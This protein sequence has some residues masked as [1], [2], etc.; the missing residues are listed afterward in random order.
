MKTIKRVLVAGAIAAT[1]LTVPMGTAEAYW[2]GPGAWVGPWRHSYVYDPNY[3]W[4]SPVMR[5]YI[6]DLYRYGPEYARWSQ[7]RRYRWW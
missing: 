3:R 5:S 7:F 1:L 6:R 4:A 2:L